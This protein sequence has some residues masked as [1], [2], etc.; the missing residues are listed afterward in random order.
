MDADS[1]TRVAAL[2]GEAGR[3][4]MLAALLDGNCHSASELALQAEVSP[5]AAS[6]H[7]SKLLAGRLV[8][9]ERN[10]RQRLFRLRDSSVA[11]AVEAIGALAQT[12][13]GSHLP[14]LR[15]ARS[16]YDH[17]AGVLAIALRNALLGSASLRQGKNMLAITSKGKRLLRSLDVD[18]DSLRELRRSFAYPCLDLTERHYHIGGA[19]G[20]SLLAALL[21]RKWLARLRGS[22]ALR[23][24]HVGEHGIEKL[25]GIR[26]AALRLPVVGQ[27]MPPRR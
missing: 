12:P 1:L 3:I 18:V 23:L 14:A 26:P 21:R 22:R 5:Q 20:A 10:G 25:F 15:F 8:V 4:R 19:L 24:T 17:L 9:C 13:V 7:L 27:P 6:S 11:H 16:C 2:V